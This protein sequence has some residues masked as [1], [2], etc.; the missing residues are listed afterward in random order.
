M[1]CNDHIHSLDTHL[2]SICFPNIRHC[3]KYKDRPKHEVFGDDGFREGALI[4]A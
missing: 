3:A 4:S 2:L 1:L